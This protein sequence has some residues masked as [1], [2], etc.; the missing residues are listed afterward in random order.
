MKE[1]RGVVVMVMRVGCKS[2]VEKAWLA[3]SL[4][5][6][7]AHR[8]LEATNGG[9]A[10]LSSPA[11]CLKWAMVAL[12][13]PSGALA[14]FVIN[15]AVYWCE[16]CRHLEWM[17]DWSTVLFAG[18]IQWFWML[19]EYRKRRELNVLQLKD[20][21]RVDKVTAPHEAVAA[22][23]SAPPLPAASTFAEFDA[24]GLTAL[25]RVLRE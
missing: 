22:L 10:P 24:A 17:L 3:T 8:W 20:V 6:F 12:S 5:V 21:G 16:G 15:D 14:M 19:P 4:L 25:D 7:V 1:A 11:T 9:F 2:R 23:A 18:Y 13:F